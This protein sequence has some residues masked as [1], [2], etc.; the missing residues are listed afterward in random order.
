MGD[1][2]GGDEAAENPT[3]RQ[4]ASE[5]DG[6]IKLASSVDSQDAVIT[7]KVEEDMDP[8]LANWFK[9][10]D[11]EKVAAFPLAHEADDDSAT[12][13]DSDH[14]DVAPDAADEVDLDDWFEVKPMGEG[15]IST[16]PVSEPRPV[17]TT[18]NFLPQD[19]HDVKMGESEVAMEY[20]QEFIFKHLQ[21]TVLLRLGILL[22][23]CSRCFYLDS[24]MNAIQHGM[25][26][27][28]KQEEE[29]EQR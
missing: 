18:S 13:D 27:K 9:V 21:V 17:L 14:A 19:Q 16:K 3:L 7:P 15:L 11:S 25:A 28:S 20:D 6:D 1:S 4:P 22:I 26:V 12:E 8:A 5:V 24:T 29:I 2:D 23:D 10:D